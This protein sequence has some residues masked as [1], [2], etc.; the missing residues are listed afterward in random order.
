MGR[1]GKNW[2]Q[3]GALALLAAIGAFTIGGCG[4]NDS[5]SGVT[6]A[7]LVLIAEPTELKLAPGATG[8]IQF[9]LT[10][11]GGRGRSAN[12]LRVALVPPESPSVGLPDIAGATLLSSEGATNAQGRLIVEL[13][14]GTVGRFRVRA[15]HNGSVDKLVSVI[16]VKQDAGRAQASVTSGAFTVPASVEMRLYRDR[17]CTDL[18]VSTPPPASALDVRTMAATSRWDLP[19][20]SISHTYALIAKGVDQS[21]GVVSFGCVGVNGSQLLQTAVTHFV[22]P[23]F[24][25]S[26]SLA[27]RYEAASEFGFSGEAGKGAQMVASAWATLSNCSNSPAQRWL[28]CTLDALGPQGATNAPL[29]CTPEADEGEVGRLLA[30]RRGVFSLDSPDCRSAKDPGGQPSADAQVFGLFPTVPTAALAA[31]PSLSKAAAGLFSRLRFSSS[32]DVSPSGKA[33]FWVATHTARSIGFPV[34]ESFFSVQLSD[35]PGRISRFI[36]ASSNEGQ[37]QLAIANHGFALDLGA[38]AHAAFRTRLFANQGF[39]IEERA[40]LDQLMAQ[41]VLATTPSPL[42]GCD[43][44]DALLCP[45]IGKPT[46]CLV[47]AC[48]SGLDAMAKGLS[49]GFD[50]LSSGDLDLFLKGTAPLADRLADGS[51]GG[52]GSLVPNRGGPGLWSGELRG[53]G[54]TSA[55]SG[56]WVAIRQ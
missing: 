16:V 15:S 56:L 33:G 19:E 45:Q 50:E 4:D 51:V 46:G 43:A 27:Q 41:A 2:L 22:V 36:V 54:S 14:A 44:M 32:L 38:A 5:A 31:L 35:R 7:D 53:R 28:D 39:P 34:G 21:G 24:S 25:I 10:D 52:L 29:D 37:T 42:S 26:I 48:L 8:Q 23:L 20:L 40:F 3:C 11:R 17:S 12:T 18:N 55:L 9:R 30:A 47:A 6:T 49:A 13:R 1:C